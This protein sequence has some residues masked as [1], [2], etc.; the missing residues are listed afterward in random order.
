VAALVALAPGFARAAGQSRGP[1]VRAVTPSRGAA[2][3]RVTV[4]GSDLSG[5]TSVRFGGVD[6]RFRV[7]SPYAVSAVVPRGAST[8]RV[9]VQTSGGPAGGGA[10]FDVVPIRHVVIIDQE[11]HSF[12]NVL[13][14][15]CAQVASAQIVRPGADS[16]CDGATTGQLPDGTTIPL[17][18]ARDIVV[19][20]DHEVPDQLLGIDGGAMDGFSRIS[21]CGPSQAYHCYSQYDGS[22]IPNVWAL[23]TDFTVSDR[24]FEF[25]S[26]ASWAGHMVLATPTLDGFMGMNPKPSAFHEA[27]YGWGCDSFK[28]SPWWDGTEYVEEPSCIPD[29][30]GNG[31]YRSSPVA[32]V[33]TI[34][35]RL[36][37]AHVSWKIYGGRGGVPGPLRSGYAWTVCATF[38]ECQGTRQHDR[39]VP[40][41][42][43]L[44]AAA[45]GTLPAY[46]L[47][48]PTGSNSQHNGDSMAQGDNWI[49]QVVSAI[50]NG[51]D[52]SSTA[53]FLTWDDCGCFYDHVPPPAPTF[54]PENSPEYP[55]IRVPMI[56]ISPYAKQ[57]FTD[58]TDA[59]FVSLLAYVEHL[60]ALPPMATEDQEA[61]DFSNAFD[62]TQEPLAP[63]PMTRTR[64]PEWELR[65]MAAHPEAANDPT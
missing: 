65:W 16:P 58:S 48:V 63:V 27:G 38:Y 50:M 22:Q 9:T 39:L 51:P 29:Q 40:A 54:G 30:Q 21:G 37:A 10:P 14:L 18:T 42:K 53:I 64:V 5:T 31:P 24:T 44:H 1:T 12:D 11:N 2:G 6:A 33:P 35:D 32:W 45:N 41:K 55:G 25:S 43:V 26:S 61:Y 49:G 15:F 47:V 3:D 28:D 59:T 8:G 20:V 60:F 19:G 52:W 7:L 13:G 57:G 36:D 46:S 34:F 56:I 62:Y 17:A 23:A 4:A